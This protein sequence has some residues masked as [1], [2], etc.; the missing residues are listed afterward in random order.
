MSRL[1]SCPFHRQAATEPSTKNADL[2]DGQQW[3]I[4]NANRT[5]TV[6]HAMRANADRTCLQALEHKSPLSRTW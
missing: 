2:T 1:L 3:Q 6:S 4:V 5:A